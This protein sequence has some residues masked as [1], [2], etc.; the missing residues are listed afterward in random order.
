MLKIT[1]LPYRSCYSYSELTLFEVQRYD[2]LSVD[3]VCNGE[4]F[5]LEIRNIRNVICCIEVLI[6][7]RKSCFA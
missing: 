5:D 1:L 3:A 4:Y 2:F 6:T 7:V